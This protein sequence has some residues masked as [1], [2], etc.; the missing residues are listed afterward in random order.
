MSKGKEERTTKKSCSKREENE[1]Q[2]YNGGYKKKTTLQQSAER[3]FFVWVDIVEIFEVQLTNAKHCL[4]ITGLGGR[5]K[6]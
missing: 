2:R 4:F 5:E 6:A 3:M 1:A